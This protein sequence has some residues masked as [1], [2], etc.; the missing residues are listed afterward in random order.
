MVWQR[1]EEFKY[2]DKIQE[3]FS[4][5]TF[6]AKTCMKLLIFLVREGKGSKGAGPCLNRAKT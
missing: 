6:I 3:K 4:R 5:L 1:Q 2:S